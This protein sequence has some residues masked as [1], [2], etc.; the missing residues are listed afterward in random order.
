MKLV[1]NTANGKANSWLDVAGDAWDVDN[2]DGFFVGYAEDDDVGVGIGVM[3][4]QD[5]YGILLAIDC[6]EVN[7]LA[8]LDIQ[9]ARAIAEWL[10][11]WVNSAEATA[12]EQNYVFG[13]DFN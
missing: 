4:S 12:R 8:R 5:I 6:G 10:T 11:Q 2:D 3:N 7:A 1:V 13:E 9:Q